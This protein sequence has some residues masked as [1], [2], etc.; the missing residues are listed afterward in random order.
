MENYI[1]LEKKQVIG[2]QV[3]FN[4]I[5]RNNI[6]FKTY[7]V[8]NEYIGEYSGDVSNIVATL[9]NY[10]NKPQSSTTTINNISINITKSNYGR[11]NYYAKYKLEQNY[12]VC[13]ISKC[14]SY[15]GEYTEYALGAIPVE[16][17]IILD[18]EIADNQIQCFY[19]GDVIDNNFVNIKPL[20]AVV[21][22]PE[23]DEVF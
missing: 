19:L 11:D 8:T 6:S 18:S 7:T 4:D 12:I 20:S 23:A 14:A 1:L 16:A 13:D 5:N 10:I 9:K 3:A 22:H 15:N 21:R 2:P 17:S